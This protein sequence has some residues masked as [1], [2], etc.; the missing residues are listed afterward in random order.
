[1]DLAVAPGQLWVGNRTGLT[2]IDTNGR[3]THQRE[4]D[5]IVYDLAYVSALVPTETGSYIG[6][7]GGIF[8]LS[9][10]GDLQRLL[11]TTEL[12]AQRIYALD[13]SGTWLA[14]ATEKGVVE[15]LSTGTYRHLFPRNEFVPSFDVLYVDGKL[16]IAT[17]YGLTIWNPVNQSFQLSTD[18]YGNQRSGTQRFAQDPFYELH[19]DSNGI[20]ACTRRGVMRF[21]ADGDILNTWLAPNTDFTPRGIAVQGNLVWIGTES[22]IW[23]LNTSNADWRQITMADGLPSNFITDLVLSGDY[24]WAGTNYGLAR[25]SWKNIVIEW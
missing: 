4:I 16:W 7:R 14:A 5:E 2:V 21:H 20:W 10:K 1:M 23:L 9:Q 12:D 25:I 6:A 11:T 13:H 18:S 19:A 8:R 17:L 15:Y 24:I 3:V 22:G